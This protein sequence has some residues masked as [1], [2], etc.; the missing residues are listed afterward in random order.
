MKSGS[1]R[2]PLP[3]N[4]FDE[5][6]SI[7][8]A[9]LWELIR[10]YQ[11][12]LE[13]GLG[14][15][16]VVGVGLL[17]ALWIALPKQS[18]ATMDISFLFPGASSGHYPNQL[19]FHPDDLLENVLLHKNFQINEVNRWMIYDDFKSSFSLRP[20]GQELL[21]LGRELQGKLDD[22]KLTLAERQKLEEEFRSRLAKI[23]NTTY[24][25]V[26]NQTGRSAQLIPTAEIEKLL[27]DIPRLW[28][29]EFVEQKKV[30]L[31]S[32]QIPGKIVASSNLDE[33]SFLLTELTDRIRALV[34]GL[35]EIKKLPGIFLAS[36][37][38]GENIADIELKTLAFLEDKLPKIRTQLF[39]SKVTAVNLKSLESAFAVQ[40]Q[41][42]RDRAQISNQNVQS[43]LATFQDYL[44][45]RAGGGLQKTKKPENASAGDKAPAGTANFQI[46]DVFF[47]KISEL[48][49]DKDGNQYLYQLLENIRDTRLASANDASAVLESQLIVDSLSENN[50]ATKGDLL[51]SATIKISAKNDSLNELSQT[52]T[53]GINGIN[54]I[55]TQAE[56]LRAITMENYGNPQTT[57]YRIVVP[58]EA[59]RSSFLTLRNAGLGLGAFV[60]V[61][62]AGIL[63][64]CWIFES[65]SQVASK[66]ETDFHAPQP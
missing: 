8:L 47:A 43:A 12:W 45:G 31:N 63:L 66:V 21:A 16:L 42:R 10:K 41:A 23:P 40:L 18:R 65:V 6:D 5:G 17:G 36:L 1:P 11:R 58:V 54:D 13:V 19:P 61:G 32:T 37:P 9:P 64:A 25:I 30:L 7:S 14:I 52:L 50:R 38:N 24:Q 46:G 56:Q 48:L 53:D 15:L 29:Q 34:M 51:A 2:E 22:R 55:I 57:M 28:A 35:N 20:S 33:S 3:E 49:Q 27:S 59:A 4:F 26:W 44:A 60:F 62:M 39:Q